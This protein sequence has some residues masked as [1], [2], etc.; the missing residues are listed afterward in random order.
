MV[1]QRGVSRPILLVVAILACALAA[2]A[3]I[4][5]GVLDR[6]RESLYEQYAKERMVPIDEASH[7]V[8][9]E[10]DNIAVDLDLA[11]ALVEDADS[12]RVAERQLHAIATVKREYLVMD[13]RAQ[14]GVRTRVTAYNAPPGAAELADAAMTRM[15]DASDATPGHAVAAPVGGTAPATWY[16][17]AHRPAGH[18]PAVAVLVDLDYL[19]AQLTPLQSGDDL[20]LLSNS[21]GTSASKTDPVLAA[22]AIAFSAM[23]AG[24]RAGHATTR[25]V[26]TDLAARLGLPATTAVAIAVPLR[27]GPA[28]AWSLLVVASTAALETQEHLLVRR[29]LAGAALV[30][31]LL[32]SAGAY[33]I[34]T[35]RRTMLLR[36]RARHEERLIRSEKLVTAGQLAAGIAH[37]IGTPLNVARGRVELV[38]AH[39]GAD[40]AEAANHRIVIDQIDRVTRQIQQLLDYVRLAPSKQQSVEVAPALRGVADLIGAHAST[41]AVAIRVDVAPNLPSLHG[42]P[43]QLQQILVN[44]GL[45]AIDACPRGGHVELRAERRGEAVALE[46]KDDGAGIA[47]D[48]RA[49]VF[50]PFFTTK[51]RGQGTGLGLWVVAQLARANAAEIELDSAPGSGTTVRVTWPVVA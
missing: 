5:A 17:F 46:V 40:H 50:D 37:E 22:E 27:I 38:L 9:A 24:A 51:K 16:V 18:G 28:P 25:I 14:G 21:S 2:L 32:L 33:V 19:F 4:G 8:A 13:A 12:A 23:I 36:E 29:V 7:A 35:T 6:D 3:A 49:Q 30:L 45:N 43:D 20:L 1:H 47:A 10:I 34:H 41:C 26:D 39:L 42:D 48:V 11:S 44:L 15:L 31:V